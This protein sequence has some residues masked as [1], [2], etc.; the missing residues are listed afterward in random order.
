[1]KRI[2]LDTHVL[3]WWV[4]GDKRLSKN[5]RRLLSRLDVGP[6]ALVPDIALWEVATLHELNRIKL[7]LPLREWLDRATAFPLVECAPITPAVATDVAAL[8]SWFHRDPADRIIVAT[9]R[10]HG[11]R[12][13][14][15]D[16][17]IID[18]DLVETVS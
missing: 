9:T 3:I 13:L 5:Q 1:M 17:R 18:A 10:V 12:L 14:T 16:Q 6:P 15:N 8:P 2:V 7:S 11:A 4:D